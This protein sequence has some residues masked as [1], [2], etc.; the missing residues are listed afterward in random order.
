MPDQITVT[1]EQ[2]VAGREQG[3]EECNKVGGKWVN[4]RMCPNCGKVGCCNSSPNQHATKHWQE[5]GHNLI[6]G[7]G[8][9]DRWTYDYVTNKMDEPEYQ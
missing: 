1:E 2:A 7:I 6:R 4:L 3:C 9:G 5:T 8:V